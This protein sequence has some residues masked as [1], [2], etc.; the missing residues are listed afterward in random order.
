VNRRLG[1]T[2]DS[3]AQQSDRED[4]RVKLQNALL[5]TSRRVTSTGYRLS[6]TSGLNPHSLYVDG[7]LLARCFAAL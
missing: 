6:R 2:L 1:A 4:K 3:F 5:E 7:P